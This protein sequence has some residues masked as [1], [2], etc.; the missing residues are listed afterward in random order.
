VESNQ[1]FVNIID[2][3]N[4]MRNL[5]FSMMCVV[6][7]WSACTT[8][9][10]MEN[11][12]ERGL[13]RAVIQSKG[14][15]EELSGKPDLLPRSMDKEGRLTT[16]DSRWWTSGFFPGTLWYLYEATGDSELKKYAE[17]YTQRVEREKNTTDNHDVGFMLYC[18]FG[19]GLRITGNQFYKSVLLQ[20]AESLSTR[21]HAGAGLIR[22][23]D[24]NEDKWQY[25]VIIDNMMNLELLL[26]ASKN[27]DSTKYKDIALKHAD[28]TMKNHYR[29]DYSSYHVVSYD[30]ITGGVEKKNTNQGYADE[31][32]WARGQ[33]WGLYG[34]T[35][36]YRETGIGRYLTMAENIANYLLSHKNM[37]ADG[38]PYWDFDAPE[39]P[40]AER[41]ASAAA[42]MASAFIE[43]STVTKDKKLSESCLRMAEKQL[44]TLSSDTYLAAPGT[45]AHFVLKH[46]V[47]NMPINA[48]VDVPLSYTDYYY[49]EALLRYKKWYDKV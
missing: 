45:N 14:M 40:N 11:V 36:M 38:I 42:I 16:S 33:A 31:S 28:K 20:G 2:I 17:I 26:W 23:W 10:P 19:N 49:V 4:V 18:S 46:S 43:L 3:F 47:G 37:P 1:L 27:S 24:F 7:V 48:E 25:P 29:P 8:Q 12:I 15:A 35:M 41:D 6:T 39:I 22:S 32:S 9:E 44:R 21:Y 30:T 13:E 5:I 34:Y